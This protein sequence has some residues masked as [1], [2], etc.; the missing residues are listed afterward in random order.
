MESCANLSNQKVKHI[1]PGDSYH[2]DKINDLS[3][4]ESN[5]KLEHYDQI[6]KKMDNVRNKNK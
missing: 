4:R 1:L 2:S 5:R 3:I 6:L